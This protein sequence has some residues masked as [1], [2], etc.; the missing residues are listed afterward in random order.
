MIGK[1]TELAKRIHDERAKKVCDLRQIEKWE[2][3]LNELEKQ[4]GIKRN[5]D[6]RDK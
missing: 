2:Q 4:I 5:G 6:Y 3:E 1:Y